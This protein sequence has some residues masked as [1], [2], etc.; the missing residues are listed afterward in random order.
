MYNLTDI[1]QMTRTA[2]IEN[3][4]W[5][6]EHSPWVAEAAWEKRPFQ[7]REDLFAALA[8]E[9]YRAPEEKQLS[10]LRA[11]PDLGTRLDV[12]DASR[13]EQAGAGL[14]EL[15]EAEYE[16]FSALNQTYT[17]RF[18]FPFILAVKGKTKADILQSLQERQFHDW[19][20]EKETA[21]AE[22]TK[23]IHF[24]LHDLVDGSAQIERMKS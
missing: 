13:S 24:R 20:T 1:N 12:T 5:T 8:R 10:L 23:I 17:S 11:H 19:E 4:G 14:H 21:I 7:S 16:T 22:V 6:A 9:I 15:S 3:I 2:F 18:T